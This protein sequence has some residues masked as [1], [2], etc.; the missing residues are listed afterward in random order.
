MGIPTRLTRVKLDIVVSVGQV[1]I[2]SL[3]KTGSHDISGR[4]LNVTINMA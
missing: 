2:S 3:I 4:L 1:P